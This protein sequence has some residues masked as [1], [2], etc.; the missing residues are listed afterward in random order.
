MISV[1]PSEAR[2]LDGPMDAVS[3]VDTYDYADRRP[4]QVTIPDTRLEEAD[5]QKF[6][7]NI[8]A[9][10]YTADPHELFIIIIIIIC[11]FH[12]QYFWDYFWPVI[13]IPVVYNF[14]IISSQHQ[15]HHK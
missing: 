1:T 4:V 8:F 2:K 12:N 15:Y 14:I 9:L 6:M 7:V 13:L 10:K 11:H 5:G 3:H